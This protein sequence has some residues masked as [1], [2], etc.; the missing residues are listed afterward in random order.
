MNTNK[1]NLKNESKYKLPIRKLKDNI[2]K[3]CNYFKFK[4]VEINF[5][6]TSDKEILKFNKKYFE[7]NV[8]TDV[9]SFP[10]EE[11]ED[12]IIHS[13]QKKYKFLG[14]VL[15]SV[16]QVDI[17]SKKFKCSFIEELNRVIIHGILHLIGY[18]DIKKS[19]KKVMFE[20]QEKILKNF[21][22]FFKL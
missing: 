13:S 8:S 7:Q 3:Y 4:N 22:K 19:E 9:I 2:I 18:D 15:I 12:F 1:I 5:L 21:K 11:S 6:F 20:L 17:N 16:E 10:D 14:D